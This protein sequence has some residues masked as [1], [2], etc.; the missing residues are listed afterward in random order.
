M[1]FSQEEIERR[2]SGE[3][4]IDRQ[5]VD[6][7]EKA[8]Q[9]LEEANRTIQNQGQRIRELESHDGT[10]E[11]IVTQGDTARTE[12]MALKQRALEALRR[13]GVVTP[14]LLVA[15]ILGALTLAHFYPDPWGGH[16]LAQVAVPAVA[17]VQ[18]EAPP[19][20]FPQRSA[21]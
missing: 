19:A 21:V 9:L 15:V 2:R 3:A 4:E 13:A 12:R 6:G 11:Q 7:A 16:Q 1:A 10:F 20:D 17:P 18:Q 14:I 8:A 5:L